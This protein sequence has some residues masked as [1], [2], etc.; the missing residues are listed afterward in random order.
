MNNVATH[1]SVP[2]PVLII[3]TGDPDDS[4]RTEHGSYA[5]MMQRSAGLSHDDVHIVKVYEN[6]PLRKPS[7][8]RAALITGSPAMVTDKESWSEQTAIWLRQAA[9]ENLPMFGVCYGHQLLSHALGGAVHD[10]PLGRELGTQVLE[11]L[12]TAIDDPLLSVLPR[13]FSAQLVHAQTVTVLPAGAVAL[14]QSALDPHQCVRLATNIY[15]TQFHPEFNP[16]F[17]Q[18]HLERYRKAYSREGF[19]IDALIHQLTTTPDA[20]PL[21]KRFLEIF[22]LPTR[23]QHY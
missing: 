15:S 14:A 17:L 7:A 3:H 13:H 16:D 10:N 1:P 21:L 11:C 4:L 22:A 8:Y 18:A 9:A 12:P 20:S 5:E 2:L 6:E 19:D 23:I